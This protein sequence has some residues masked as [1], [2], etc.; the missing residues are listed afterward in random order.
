MKKLF[1]LFLLL[2][3]TSVFAQPLQK[4]TV[5]LDWFINPDHAPLIVAQQQGYFKQQGLEVNLITP[6]N[7]NDGPKL[8]AAGKAEITLEYQIS[9]LQQ[10]EEGLPLVRVGSLFPTNL[11][12][13][14]VLQNGPIKTLKDLTGKTVAMSD[15]ESDHVIL[16]AMLKTQ[17]VD[18]TTVT[19]INVNYNLVQALLSHRVDAVTGIMR[20]VEPI[21]M[22]VRGQPVRLFYPEDYGVPESEAEIWVINRNNISKAWVNK[23]LTAIQQGT[24][25][26]QA[27][28]EQT[29]NAF[30]KAY[31]QLN[32]K[33]NYQSWMATYKLF[34]KNP[35][36]CNTAQYQKFAEFVQQQGLIKKV[37]PLKLYVA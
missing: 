20:N 15:G 11:G 27:H 23:F 31:P 5:I 10:V 16:N 17:G 1:S 13:I 34:S 2:I 28:P 33:F 29:W 37:P 19:V 3:S 6:A 4:I 14:A 26:L 22:Q 35:R 25:Y 8:V 21:E 7:P 18:P 36:E 24:V 32:T 12:A 9:L 30:A